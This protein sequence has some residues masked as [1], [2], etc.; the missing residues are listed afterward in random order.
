MLIHRNFDSLPPIRRPAATIGSYDGV[1]AGHRAI[2]GR[3]AD[4]ARERGGESVVVTFDPHPRSVVG[5]APVMLLNTLPEKLAL[6]A[7]TG[8]D[9]AVVVDFTPEFSRL[10]MEEF[11]ERDLVG[12]LH[13]DTLLVGYNHHLGRDK[14]GDF[15]SLSEL[16]RRSGFDVR[17]MPRQDVDAHKVSSTVIRGLVAGGNLRDAARCL[18]APYFL[19]GRL[20]A[21]G[22]V[23]GVE[24]GKLLPPAGE[25]AVRVG[26]DFSAEGADARLTIGPGRALRLHGGEECLVP[27]NAVVTFL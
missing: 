14:R 26:R 13:V 15:D 27:G 7:G 24:S 4:I 6:L 20:A 11:V 23:L 16:G 1:H 18:G 5:S 17:M 25:Y 8:I 19:S 22:T 9:H 12:R 3:I 21:D 2:L 10:S